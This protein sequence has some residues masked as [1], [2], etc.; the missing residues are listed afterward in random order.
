MPSFISALISQKATKFNHP[1]WTIKYFIEKRVHGSQI[2]TSNFDPRRVKFSRTLLF[3]HLLS[4]VCLFCLSHTLRHVISIVSTSRQY[5]FFSRVNIEKKKKQVFLPTSL[6]LLNK[7]FR[8]HTR[9]H[10]TGPALT[11]TSTVE[12]TLQINRIWPTLE[13][14]VV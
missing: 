4:A 8:N 12:I 9:A 14:C 5:R 6:T 3:P 1:T 2:N 13:C 7:K 10:V 11:C